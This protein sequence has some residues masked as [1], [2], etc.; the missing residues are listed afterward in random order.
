MK[1]FK[2]GELK[3]LWPF[4]LE[5]LLT[6]LLAFAAVFEILFFQDLGLSFTQ[7][8]IILMMMP[9][10]MLIFE[11]PTGA[12]ADLYGRKLSVLFGTLVMGISMFSIFFI[13][14]YYFI[15]LMFVLTGFGMTFISGAETAWIVDLIKRNKKDFIHGYFSKSQFFNGVGVFLSGFI[16]AFLVKLFGVSIIWI[17]GGLANFLA[18]SIL[19]FGQEHFVRRKI[20]IRKSFKKINKQTKESV[21]Y[22]WKHP[23]L[24]SIL[25][26][27]IIFV[28]AGEFGGTISWIPFL[29][30]LGFPDYAFGYLWSGLGL[31][32]AVTPMFSLK[33]AKKNKEKN[34]IV[35][36]LIAAI[37]PLLLILFVS[38]I[39]LA[40]GIVL[41]GAFFFALSDPVEKTYFHRFVVSKLRATV[42]SFMSLVLSIAGILAIPLAG[43]LVDLIGPRYTLF[44]S[45][46][47]MM[48]GIIIYSRIKE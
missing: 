43:Y 15:L 5:A 47:V 39:I 30:S 36:S 26:A 34:F 28:F 20:K 14:N 17:A 38:E 2:K 32:I 29:E 11:L 41:T 23:V 3:L 13:T 4:Y 45:A 46:I 19:I 16:G 18:A 24:F 25:L 35:L 7:M 1:L 42:G 22:S 37:V 10:S 6:P 31:I 33:F 21:N 8:G 12:F 9:L 48:P 44:I 27:G 40:L